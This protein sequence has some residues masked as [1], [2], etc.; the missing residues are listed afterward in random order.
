MGDF[1]LKGVNWDMGNSTNSLEN[2]FVNGFADLGLL[3]CID[4][5]TH[6][7][8]K[9]LDIFLTKS[10]QYITDL[11]IIDTERYCISAHYAVTSDSSPL[12]GVLELENIVSESTS[13]RYNVP[14]IH[15]ATTC[16][17]HYL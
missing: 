17:S 7:N 15:S 2:E 5:P 12:T 9:I 1:N 4:A 13:L 10:K 16:K 6:N 8:G 11:K 14:K 3:Q